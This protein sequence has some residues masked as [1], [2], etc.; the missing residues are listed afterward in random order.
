MLR[1]GEKQKLVIVKQVD[2]GVYLAKSMEQQQDRVLLPKKQVAEGAAI[3][4]EVE[5][6]LYKDSK[7]RLIATINEPKLVMGQVAR[8]VVSSKVF[9]CSIL[10]FCK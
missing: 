1:L 5:V 10:V 2:F 3:G 6:F 7:D 4:D 9:A 8:L